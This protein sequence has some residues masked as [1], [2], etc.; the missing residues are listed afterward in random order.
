MSREGQR[1]EQIKQ[2]WADLR[3]AEGLSADVLSRRIQEI[4]F[5]CLRCGECCTGE[6]NS[7]VVFPFE[8]R[9][10]L[11]VAGLQWLEAVEPPKEG[12]WDRNGC[13]HTLEWRLK[14]DGASCKFYLR[15]VCGICG[16]GVC[17]IYG[18]R[19]LICSTYPFYLDRGVLHF[20][21][22]R[23]LGGE[24][25]PD[26]AK[27]MAERLIL[28]QVTEIREAVALLEKYQDFER[29]EAG[30]DGRRIVHDSEGEHCL[31]SRS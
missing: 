18:S 1:A 28:R 15:S 27:K 2:L 3:A 10:I 16:D 13:F 19:P 7:V 22:C 11:A 26:T 30:E 8:V 31:P 17:R 9:R 29:G 12:E 24:V 20:S 5:R 14:K 4:G 23:G 25:E 21:E 6:D